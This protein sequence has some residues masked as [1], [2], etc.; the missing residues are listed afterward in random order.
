[1]AASVLQREW[2]RAQEYYSWCLSLSDKR[3]ANW[4]LM[5]SPWPTLALAAAYL[6]IVRVG[7]ALMRNRKPYEFRHVL[8][9]YNLAVMMLNLY[10]GLELAVVSY[11]L[12]YS[13]FCQPVDYSNK[14]DEIR[15]AAALW[16]YYISKLVEFCD[17]MFFILRKKNNQLT[18]L[19]VYHH[20]TMFSLWWIGVKFVAGGSSFLAAMMNSFVHVIM[21]SYYGL[22][23][24]GPGIQ[25]YLWWKKHITCIQLVQFSCAGVLGIRALI[26]GCSFPL[27]MQYALVV[28]MMS[29]IVLFG[30]FYAQSYRK[31]GACLSS[32]G[33]KATATNGRAQLAPVTA[34][35]N[36]S[37][38]RSTANGVQTRAQL[39]RDTRP[40]K[41]M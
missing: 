1:M 20:S 34:V 32:N 8:I 23:A 31:K 26:V 27:W 7:P 38:K 9:V 12:G 6:T 24:L 13:W 4:P 17:T 37:N 29:F 39:R 5:A 41:D 40:R 10:I 3:V 16:W 22:S 2:H 14:P 35:T 11:R 36:T 33:V 25:R 15:I 18:F 30:K 19:H 21:Y 28:Y